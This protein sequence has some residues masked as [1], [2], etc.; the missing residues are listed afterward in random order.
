MR[1]LFLW[2]CVLCTVSVQTNFALSCDTGDQRI[3]FELDRSFKGL[4]VEI[5]KATKKIKTTDK[6]TFATAAVLTVD[7]SGDTQV[8]VPRESVL[9]HEKGALLTYDRETELEKKAA[10]AAGVTEFRHV[11]CLDDKFKQVEYDKWNGLCL[12]PVDLASTLKKGEEIPSRS[13]LYFIIYKADP[14]EKSICSQT[15]AAPKDSGLEKPVSLKTQAAKFTTTVD[16]KS[17]A[18]KDYS[19]KDLQAIRS[20]LALPLFKFVYALDPDDRARL[21]VYQYRLFYEN[22]YLY[23]PALKGQAADLES[24]VQLISDVPVIRAT[25]VGIG[26]TAGQKRFSNL[27]N[28]YKIVRGGVP[29]FNFELSLDL[30]SS[31]ARAKRTTEEIPALELVRLYYS[32]L[33]RRFLED[34]GNAYSDYWEGIADAA[35]ILAYAHPT[36]SQIASFSK[37][38]EQLDAAQ[39]GDRPA[40]V[41]TIHVPEAPKKKEEPKQESMHEQP[42]TPEPFT[43]EPQQLP[44]LA[45]K[46]LEASAQKLMQTCN[47]ISDL[48]QK[49]TCIVK[50]LAAYETSA[51]MEIVLEF[52]QKAQPT[53]DAFLNTVIKPTQQVIQQ[54]LAD[55]RAREAAQVHL[56]Q[57]YKI[58][59]ALVKFL[60]LITPPEPAQV[61]PAHEEPESAPVPAEKKDALK[62][63]KV[64]H[65]QIHQKAEQMKEDVVH[66]AEELKTKIEAQA[67]E[68][69]QKAAETAKKI[70]KFFKR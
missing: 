48:N 2:L 63:L 69:K 43:P 70:G 17:V 29:A 56:E 23:A 49:G 38:K 65:E 52:Y 18:F 58:D 9:Q 59:G 35:D 51:D 24:S 42:E 4:Y 46:D 36:A 12:K 37:M 10:V 15:A 30:L 45:P 6:A 47:A 67:Q 60:S 50:D 57:L 1:A 25:Y 39:A 7:N 44:I 14:T 41:L 21:G 53:V 34:L 66:K 5:I 62:E 3:K 61:I 27:V 28:A 22:R 11:F 54:Y 33:V 64:L 68:V 26:Q 13:Y 31:Q 20:E 40:A 16:L 19:D 32:D 8:F 55:D